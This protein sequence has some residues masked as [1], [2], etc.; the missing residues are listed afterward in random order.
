MLKRS[1]LRATD[2]D[3]PC[4]IK[5]VVRARPLNDRELQAKTSVVVSVS[6]T[7]VQ[8]VNPVVFSDPS[9][10]EAAAS[11]LALSP[12]TI[13]AATNAGECRTFHFDR[14]FGSSFGGQTDADVDEGTQR[15]NQELIFDEIGQSVIES[16]FQGF[17]CTMFAY[18]QTGSGKTHTMVGD[19][20]VSGKGVIP[21]VCEALFREID[22]RREKEALSQEQDGDSGI[23]RTIYT[24]HVSYCEIYKEKVND[25]L[26]TDGNAASE[27][28]RPSFT[29]QTQNIDAETSTVPRRT[30]KVR[31]HPVTGP[32][33]EGLSI[34]SVTSYADIAEEMLAGEKLRTV[35]STL[36]NAVSSRS[37][38]VFTITITQTT[39][40]PVSQCANEKTSKISMIDLAGSE[41]ANVSGTS[42]DRLKEGA[43]INKSLTTLGRVISALSKQAADRIPYRDSTLTWLLKESLG[44][45]AKTTMFAMIS[46]SSDNYDET[47]STLRYAESAKKVMN[48]AVVNEDKNARIIRQLRQEIEEL[49]AQLARKEGSP[50][51]EQ[52]SASISASLVERESFYAEL[53]KEVEFFRSQQKHSAE[54]TASRA[55]H[56]SDNLPSLVN[57]SANLVPGEALAYVLVEGTTLFGSDPNPDMTKYETVEVTHDADV[58]EEKSAESTEKPAKPKKRHGSWTST[59]LRRRKSSSKSTP[60]TPSGKASRKLEAS[61]V[62]LALSADKRSVMQ[63]CKLPGG[64]V[65]RILPR[66]ARFTCTRGVRGQDA[67]SEEDSPEYIVELESLDPTAILLVN[68]EPLEYGSERPMQLHHGDQVRLGKPYCFRIHVPG[69]ATSTPRIAEAVEQPPEL[70]IDKDEGQDLAVLV[71]EANAICTKWLLNT[72]FAV[73]NDEKPGTVI[74]KKKLEAQCCSTVHWDRTMLELKL[75][76]LR[77]FAASLENVVSFTVEE[78]PKIEDLQIPL[79]SPKVAVPRLPSGLSELER[80]SSHVEEKHKKAEK[81]QHKPQSPTMPSLRLLGYGRLYLAAQSPGSAVSL[82][83]AIY[84]FTAAFIGKLETR[85]EG[86]SEAGKKRGILSPKEST[87]SIH[88]I[89]VHLDKMKFDAGSFVSAS[90]ISITLKENSASKA[91]LKTPESKGEPAEEGNTAK[92]FSTPRVPPIQAS[93]NDNESTE[94]DRKTFL[95]NENFETTIAAKKKQL[96]NQRTAEEESILV[97]VW[98]YDVKICY[99]APPTEEVNDATM[100]TQQVEFYVS[101]DVEERE[102]D[103]LYHSVAVKP[104]GALRLHANRSRRLI[105]R[106]TQSDQQPF[107]LTKVVHVRIAAPDAPSVNRTASM[108]RMMGK[109]TQRMLPSSRMLYEHRD[110]SVSG[111]SQ[112]LELGSTRWQVLE[113]RGD[114]GVDN[115]SRSLSAVLR[116]DH[117]PDSDLEPI[118]TAGSRSTYRLAIAFT[119]RWSKVPIVIS[120]SLVAKVCGSNVS[121][122]QRFTRGLVASRTVWWAKESYSRSYRLGTWYAADIMVDDS[123]LDESPVSGNQPQDA[124]SMN[125]VVIAHHISGLH[126]LEITMQLERVRQKVWIM[127]NLRTA[128]GGTALSESLTA[129]K[130]NLCLDEL[131]KRMDGDVQVFECVQFESPELY[132]RH[133]RKNDLLMNLLTGK[134]VDLVA[135]TGVENTSEKAEHSTLKLR[136]H[137]I[138]F[139]SEPTQLVGGDQL[140]G[141]MSGF[142]MISLSSSLDEE[143]AAA[144]VAPLGGTSVRPKTPPKAGHPVAWERQ[145]FVLKRPFLYAYVSFARKQQTGVVDLSMCQLIVATSSDVPFSFRLVCVDGRKQSAVWWLQA[146]TA[147]EM[148]AWLVAIDPLKIEARQSVASTLSAAETPALTA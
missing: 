106:V 43:M 78:T 25:L 145:W 135:L 144:V 128:E 82:S 100:E 42:G 143:T 53:Q 85:L 36:M 62:A 68:G 125:D 136:E 140:G 14:C 29:T 141:E 71:D 66:H 123:A 21:R 57:L 81:A 113:F 3:A 16:A 129:V 97:E 126:R 86:I 4:A 12:A 52:V 116:W 119:S 77:E 91:H 74:V 63:I 79:P 139:V 31:E 134:M 10:L 115:P 35:A 27:K 90:N 114:C 75:Q 9:V 127:M 89:R 56:L 51:K 49:R 121:A 40:D 34:R 60:S 55:I 138:H 38:A 102:V 101:V 70:D 44:G 120:K 65:S 24:A 76:F 11:S 15:P 109:T 84:D 94:G 28:Q 132:L 69:Y 22:A 39:F 111:E 19:K 146:S 99:M 142:L 13:T 67:A 45:N 110:Q 54:N 41:R 98:G 95:L 107:A 104:D 72:E 117:A 48:R 118:N 64:D 23:K 73:G 8:V 2:E 59:M 50:G 6:R 5:V 47:M 130:V 124:A 26:D 17:N 37:H 96:F 133:L 147:A 33:V 83:V 58:S 7:G 30:L 105:V 92:I 88:R 112:S 1:S 46:P 18:G 103:G 32:F 61:E 137:V 87:T 148:R 93:N 131:F 108:S 122:A 80:D 20:S